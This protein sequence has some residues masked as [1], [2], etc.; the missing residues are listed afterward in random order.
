MLPRCLA[1][2]VFAFSL[3][4]IHAKDDYKLGPDSMQQEG[5]PKGK[6]TEHFTWKSEVFAGTVRDYWV[7]VPAAVRRQEAGLR[8]GLPGRRRLT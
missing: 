8:H 4:I 5:V 7:Y 2:I 3:G 6:V 1:V